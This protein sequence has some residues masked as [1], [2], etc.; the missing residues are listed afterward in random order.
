MLIHIRFTASLP[1]TCRELTEDFPR[2]FQIFSRKVFRFVSHKI[3]PRMI[4]HQFFDTSPKPFRQLHG[5]YTIKLLLTNC[6]FHTENIRT[7]AFVR[8]SFHLVRTSKL[9][10]EYFAVWTS[11]LVDKSI[12]LPRVNKLS[13]EQS[14]TLALLLSL[15]CSNSLT[16]SNQNQFEC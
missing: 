14:V 5:G 11:H 10:F 16:Q 12:I 1:I 4:F 3:W 7:L 8:T 15:A 13:C 6:S 9:Q 2:F